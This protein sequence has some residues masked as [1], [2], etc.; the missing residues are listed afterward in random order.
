LTDGKIYQAH[1]GGFR[2]FL[3]VTFGSDFRWNMRRL[4]VAYRSQYRP[5]PSAF[6]VPLHITSHP[7]ADDVDV[8]NGTEVVQDLNAVFFK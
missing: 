3:H 2:V 4:C 1:V 5:P 6:S 8:T 7:L